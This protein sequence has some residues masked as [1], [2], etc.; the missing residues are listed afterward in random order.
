MDFYVWPTCIEREANPGSC[1]SPTTSVIIIVSMVTVICVSHDR[2]WYLPQK[3][4]TREK[5]ENNLLEAGIF[6]RGWFQKGLNREIPLVKNCTL[7]GTF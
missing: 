6:F 1:S 2:C 3:M 7:S 5:R 4:S